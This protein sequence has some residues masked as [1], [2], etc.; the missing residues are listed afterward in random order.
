MNDVHHL[1]MINLSRRGLIRAAG[2]AAGGGV[3][4][5]AGVAAP[6]AQAQVKKVSQK[7]VHYRPTPNGNAQCS[8]CAHFLPPSHCG[9][10]QGTVSP[11]GWCSLFA[12]KL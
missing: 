7:Q 4:I 2:V 8:K 5:A 3:L 6:S 12:P 1:E 10:V 9:V 11:H